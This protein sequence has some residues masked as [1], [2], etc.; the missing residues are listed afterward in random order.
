MTSPTPIVVW[1][2]GRHA[3]VVVDAIRAAG[4][5]EVWGLIDD[6]NP[7]RAGGQL[8]GLPVFGGEGLAH[9][10]A[11][12]VTHLIVAIG[13]NEPRVRCADRARELGF[14]LATVVH[15]TAIVG[16]G[17]EIGEGSFVAAG[18]IINPKC[19]IGNNVLINTKAS[20]DHECVLE[21]GVHIG[22][23]VTL[24]GSVTVHTRARV[25]LG[26]AVR[27]DVSI[28]RGAVVGVGA[29]V[30]SDIEDGVVAY[31]V[32]ARPIRKGPSDAR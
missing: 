29:A 5:W 28:G 15:P 1:G 32:P 19:R 26:A 6:V 22:P 24:G 9:A 31:G 11:E 14:E 16:S 10:R 7:D 18:A 25:A 21:D 17:V 8:E 23:G 2:A 30:V 27:D 20:V 12:K 3:L 13:D 4:R